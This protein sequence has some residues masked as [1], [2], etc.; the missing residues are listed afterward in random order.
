MINFER[1]YRMIINVFFSWE[2]G[3]K[4]MFKFDDMRYYFDESKMVLVLLKMIL[5]YCGDFKERN[6]DRV[7]LL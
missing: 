6:W 1:D 5:Y 3:L 7:I 4:K 2:L